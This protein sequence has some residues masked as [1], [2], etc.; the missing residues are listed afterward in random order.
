MRPA[1]FVISL[2]MTVSLVA[3]ARAVDLRHF[4]DAPLRAVQFIDAKEGWAVGDDGV[5]WHTIDGGKNWE[6]QRTGVRASLRSVCFLDPYVGWAVGREE[7][8]GGGSVGTVLF[9]RDGGVEWKR[10]LVNALP[11]LNQVRF[12]NGKVGFLIGDGADQFPTGLF[13]TSDGGKT[14]DPVKGPRTPAWHGADFNPTGGGVFVGP[15]KGLATMVRGEF[16]KARIDDVADLGARGLHAVQILEQRI[17][18][19]GDGGLVLTSQSGGTAWG[20]AD[21]KLPAEV[22]ACLDFRAVFGLGRHAW[23]VG[24]PGTVVLRSSD[25]GASWQRHATGQPLPLHGVFFLDEHRGWAVGDLGTILATTD[26]GRSWT[27]QRQGGKRAAMLLIHARGTDVPWDTVADVGA[28]EGHFVAALR[29]VAADP[30]TAQPGHANDPQRFHAATRLAGGLAGESLWQFP[31]PSHLDFSDKAGLLA[32]WNGAHADRA[33]REMLRQLV[34]ALRMWR[35]DVVVTDAPGGTANNRIGAVVAEAVRAAV[36]QA[37]DAGAF[38]EQIEQL[39]LAAWPV[40]KVVAPGDGTI[41]QDNL[42][43]VPRLEGGLREFAASAAALLGDDAAVPERRTYVILTSKAAGAQGQSHVMLGCTPAVGDARRPIVT[44]DEADPQLLDGLRQRRHLLALVERTDQ[45]E[46]VLAQLAGLSRQLSEEQAAA[47]VFAIAQGLARRGQWELAREAFLF[48][49]DRYPGHCSAVEAYRWLIRHNA[50]TEVRRRH[51]LKQFVVIKNL[52]F[53]ETSPPR[54]A[55]PAKDQPGDGIQQTK[56]IAVVEKGHIAFLHNRSEARQWYAG[57]LE[58]GK[59]LAACG[60]LFA[61]EPAVQFCLQAARRTL[62]D[63]QTPAAW[64]DNFKKHVTKGPWHDAAHA[65]AWLLN[66]GLPPPRRLALCRLTEQRPYLDGK[67]DDACW[68]GLRPL[69]LGNAAGAT[70][71]DYPTEAYFAYDQE[72][73]YVALHCRHPEG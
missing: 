56:G 21:L 39:G 7:L 52:S 73:L 6:R 38:P 44:A 4:D 46:Q 3:A 19:V 61:S 28:K 40:K 65:E 57:S 48:L 33:E 62:G 31:Q 64:Y 53:H 27:V 32:Y 54:A 10:L 37:A 30:K 50:S 42:A 59:R 20:F 23:I 60:P 68:E 35:P 51:E 58:F 13:Q 49:V 47:A 1:A 66:Q 41:V 45:L 5:V 63:Q 16:A 43:L 17:V 22:A 8:P 11:G 18:A 12:L 26:G 36:Q 9:T 34:L 69:R 55:A 71:H 72:Y 70:A 67:L 2:V 14:W 15:W 29:L 24:R 25:G